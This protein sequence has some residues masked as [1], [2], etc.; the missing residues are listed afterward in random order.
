MKLGSLISS[1]KDS[2]Y[3]MHLMKEEGHEIVCLMTMKSEN[4]HSYMFH[5]PTIEMVKLQSKSFNIPLIEHET[6]GEKEK[7]LVDL[8]EIIKKAKNEF[9]IEGITTGALCSQYQKER[10]EKICEDLSLECLSP[11]W[12]M[13]QEKE[14]RSII[15]AGFKFI[16]VRVASLGLDESWLGKEITHDAVDELVK[17]NKKIGM[18]IAFEGGEAESL[19]IDG[20]IFNKKI[21]IMETEKI[22]ENEHIGNLIIKKAELKNKT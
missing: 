20:P 12:G 14:L 8:I 22:M 7:E 2:V 6:K 10:I 3:A 9:G 11:L 4:Q 18:N 13:D 5:T 19:V 21:E 1:G 16:I 15:D 17:L